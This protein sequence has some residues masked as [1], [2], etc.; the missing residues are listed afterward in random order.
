MYK[1]LIV[2]DEYYARYGLRES[3]DWAQYDCEIIGEATDAEEAY[4]KCS[5]YMPDIVITDIRMEDT[6]GL[7]FIKKVYSAGGKK[8]RFIILSGYSEF[9]YAARAIEYGVSAYLTKPVTNSDL[10]ETIE[11][12]KK[13]I[14]AERISTSAMNTLEEELPKI[15]NIFLSNWLSGRLEE[16][17]ITEK[18]Q[19]Y[20]LPINYPYFCIGAVS[21]VSENTS[22]LLR[23]YI[24]KLLITHGGIEILT[25]DIINE[26]AFIIFSEKADRDALYG[27]FKD[28]A[29]RLSEIA[30]TP[31][32]S[33]ISN[34]YDSI[35]YVP[36]AF[37]EAKK[38]L[39]EGGEQVSAVGNYRYETLRALA[40]IKDEFNLQIS[41][42]YVAEKINVSTSHFMFLF[43]TDTGKTFSE[44]LTEY[45][46][47]KAVEFIKSHKYKIYEISEKVGY[48]NP[49]Y[50]R[51]QFKK[52][53]G[54]KPTDY[55]KD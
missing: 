34:M 49:K 28:I 54:K 46:I 22:T 10:I 11:K 33:G 5:Q 2:D 45:R 36:A 35:S 6:N 30:D 42:S 53:T 24:S 55:Y 1:I 15:K 47:K 21:H 29:N 50:F 8:V 26:Y 40:I 39:N 18:S 23:Q 52:Y 44:Y 7:D 48:K 37:E 13:E 9:S 12:V 3:I 20:G 4:E 32:D 31:I 16:R 43:K 38:M 17:E 14:D 25:A 51:K 27:I 41:A 19:K